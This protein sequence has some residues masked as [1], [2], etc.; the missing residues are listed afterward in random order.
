MLGNHV[1]EKLQCMQGYMGRTC[2]AMYSF[3][4]VTKPESL[5]EPKMPR[6]PCQI[7]TI[8]AFCRTC[9]PRRLTMPSSVTLFKAVAE[10][11]IQVMT[12][13]LQMLIQHLEVQTDPHDPNEAPLET[14]QQIQ[15]MMEEL[16]SQKATLD[17]VLQQRKSDQV[18]MGKTK[19]G[20]SSQAA[21]CKIATRTP[22]AAVQSGTGSNRKMMSPG[23]SSTPMMWCLDESD[24]DVL[25]AEEE[26]EIVETTTTQIPRISVVERSAATH[27]PFEDWG[28]HVITWGKKHKDKTFE[29]V[30]IMDVGYFEWCQRRYTSLV[31][32]MKEFVR[33]GQLRLTRL[34]AE[35]SADLA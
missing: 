17:Q 2:S 32:E 7:Q 3:H 16:H 12:M 34:A 30:M 11:L 6:Q 22:Q 26:L 9:Q 31:P 10:A 19:T 27:P 25:V 15:L 23:A 1:L 20:Q 8:P 5:S 28:K 18:S 33:Y 4:F 21:R 13:L 24:E 14:S 29:Q 35:S